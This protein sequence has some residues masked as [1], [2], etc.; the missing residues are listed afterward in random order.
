MMIHH[1][2]CRFTQGF[3]HASIISILTYQSTSLLLVKG[4]RTV[5]LA[6]LH[7]HVFASQTLY[8]ICVSDTTECLAG[9]PEDG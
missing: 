6:V 7:C 5:V 1:Q 8:L 2:Q 3:A 4:S 9:Q